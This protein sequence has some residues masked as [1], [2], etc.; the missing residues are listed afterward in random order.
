MSENLTPLWA[1]FIRA[2][3][4]EVKPALGCTEPVSLALACAIAA[5]QLSGG[6]THI[7]AWVSPNLMKNGL[8]VTVPGT[9][10]VGLPVAAAL[11]AI[12]GNAHAGLEVLKDATEE[13]IFR[14]RAMLE[15]G[16]VHVM[17]EEQSDELLYSRAKVYAGSEWASA[18]ISG[19][20][21]RVVSVEKNGKVCFSLDEET[22]AHSTSPLEVLSH[23][24]LEEIVNFVTNVPLEDIRFILDAARLNDALSREGLNKKWGL[25]I[26]KTL[27]KQSLRGLIAQDLAA[28]IVIRTSA[29]S[30]ARMGGATLPAMSNSGSGN[31]GI[32]ATM[33]VV[34]V[35]EYL[36]SDSEELARALMLSHLTAIY[37][38]HQLPRLSA[39]CAATTAAM[40]AAAGMAWLFDGRYQSIAMAI[41]SMIGDVSGMICDG[42]SN[43]CAM[44][45]STSVSSAWK[46]VLLALDD[47]AVTGDEGIVAHDV[48]QSIANLCTLARQSMQETDRQIIAIMSRKVS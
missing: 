13:D 33:P 9:G 24:N 42:A 46:S 48:E 18:T 31:Q 45:V 40:G 3:Q 15:A 16:N 44:K 35:A 26:G 34:V 41:G 21:T 28:D 12:G 47:S 7:D 37:I 19:G 23:T 5:E 38:H 6:I 4:E 43:S 1:N 8:G 11:G 32:A 17:L 27:Q 10:M 2:V 29:A 20:H 25:H 36:G 30:D 39:L 14:A 22:D